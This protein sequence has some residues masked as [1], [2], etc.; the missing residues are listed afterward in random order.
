MKLIMSKKI[1]AHNPFLNGSSTIVK[2]VKMCLM[3]NVNYKITLIQT[4]LISVTPVNPNI[5]MNSP[6]KEH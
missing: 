2:Y 3:I 6:A 4:T 1:L 5:M